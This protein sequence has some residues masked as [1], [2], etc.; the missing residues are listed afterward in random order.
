MNWTFICGAVPKTLM[1][2]LDILDQ[3][4][5]KGSMLTRGGY[6]EVIERAGTQLFDEGTRQARPVRSRTCVAQRTIIKP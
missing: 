6:G 5:L 3:S 2:E 1:S 4:A